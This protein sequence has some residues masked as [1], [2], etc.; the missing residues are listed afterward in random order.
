MVCTALYDFD[1]KDIDATYINDPNEPDLIPLQKGQ[2]VH[3]TDE[4]FNKSTE[5]WIFVNSEN[6]EISGFVPRAYLQKYDGEQSKV[7]IADKVKIDSKNLA[8]T[9]TID[10]SVVKESKMVTDDGQ[11]LPADTIGCCC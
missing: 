2:L 4:E 8:T 5:S 7:N 3:A 1:L 9:T 11:A 6:G 10:E